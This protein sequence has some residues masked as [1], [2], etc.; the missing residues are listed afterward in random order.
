[1]PD[2]IQGAYFSD[3]KAVLSASYAVAFSHLY[4]YDLSRAETNEKITLFGVEMPLYSFDSDSLTRDIKIAP[5]SEEI[6]LV[7]GKR[8]LC[9]NPLR[10]NTFSE[11]SRARNGAMPPIFPK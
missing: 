2:L 4:E 7:N 6:V 10:I 1:M 11:N 8:M 5:M 9:A 3:G